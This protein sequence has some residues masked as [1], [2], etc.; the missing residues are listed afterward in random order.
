MSADIARRDFSHDR[1]ALYWLL[2]YGADINR[3]DEDRQDSDLHRRLRGHHDYSLKVLNRIA[4]RGDTQLFNDLVSRG[5][6]PRRSIALHRVSE[7]QD[8]ATCIAMI[9]KLLDKHHMAIEADN[10]VFH[11]RID[12]MQDSET[13]L[14]CALYYENIAAVNHLLKRRA[15]P[16][17][18]VSHSVGM[19]YWRGEFLPA[20]GPLLDAGADPDA[21]L[22]LTAT[23]DDIKAAAIYLSR[24]FNPRLTII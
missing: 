20:L 14:N 16:K 23:R 12:Y 17:S 6:D 18:A 24:G 11:D 5:A 19:C 1:E 2:D 8:A 13:P 4:A 15:N 21:A 9:D 3:T 7:C 10:D 22:E